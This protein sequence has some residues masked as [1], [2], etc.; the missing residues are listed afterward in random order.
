MQRV[1]AGHG[2]VEE[3]EDLRLLRHIRRN[4]LLIQTVRTGIDELRDIEVSPRNMVLLPLLVILDAL[5]TKERQ[6]EQS[7][8]NKKNYQQTFF[9]ALRRPHCQRHE[10]T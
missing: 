3:E 4:R 6:S 2:K 8:E 1:H 9:P 5:D 7:G 10:K